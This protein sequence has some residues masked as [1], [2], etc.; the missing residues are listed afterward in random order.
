M[1]KKWEVLTDAGWIVKD[2]EEEYIDV[3]TYDNIV[4]KK[5]R[6]FFIALGG[7]EKLIRKDGLVVKLIST[8]PSGVERVVY[9]FARNG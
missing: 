6:D 1:K 5:T 2:T 9:E 8:S 4:C 3:K 7:T